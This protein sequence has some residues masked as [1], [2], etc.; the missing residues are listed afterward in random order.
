MDPSV[1]TEFESK[2]QAA[3]RSMIAFEMEVLLKG[4]DNAYQWFA[5]GVSP[6]IDAEGSLDGWVGI[7]TGIH[8]LKERS[9]FFVR[10]V[11]DAEKEVRAQEDLFREMAD[12]IEEIFW[13]T[14]ARGVVPIFVSRAFEKMYG[15]TVESLKADPK[16]FFE[17]THP[18]DRVKLAAHI[19]RQRQERIPWEL[20]FRICRPNGE[21][22]WLW[23]RSF[24]VFDDQGALIRLCGIT[25]D[26]TERKVAEQRVS[27][28]YSTVSHELRTPLTSIRGALGLLDGGKGG[29]LSVLGKQL[30]SVG[31]EECDRLV[32]LVNDFLD[33]RK[34]EANRLELQ[35]QKL[36]PAHLVKGTVEAVTPFASERHVEL[37]FDAACNE[38]V[39]ADKDKMVQVLTNL[40]S[41]AVKFSPAQSKVDIRTVREGSFV[42]FSVK[43]NGPGIKAQDQCKLFQLFQQICSSESGSGEGTGLGL[44]ICKALTERMGGKIGVQSEEGKGALFFCDIPIA[45]RDAKDAKDAKSTKDA[46]EGAANTGENADRH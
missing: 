39:L 11:E 23:A 17:A 6:I 22:R 36:E 16:S 29:D 12:N 25:S 30:V 13:V 4:A 18:D 33:M 1:R 3:S 10:R 28:F 37:D 5:L 9:E 7:N 35:L 42:R 46:P 31:R 26:I 15:R 40:V 38:R 21:I 32:R 45:P 14:D 27:E 34:I 41:N 20:E 19:R 43:D 44:A 8:E 2:W 24:S